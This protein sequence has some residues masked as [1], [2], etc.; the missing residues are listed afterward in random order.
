MKISII[1]GSIASSPDSAWV[2]MRQAV[3]DSPAADFL[4]LPARF[5]GDAGAPDAALRADVQQ[6]LAQLAREKRCYIVG[7]SLLSED[8]AHEL[9]WLFDR[10]GALLHTH[11]TPLDPGEE[12]DD[13]LFP[14]IETDVGRIGI[15]NGD[16]IWVLE[17][18]RILSLQGAEAVFVP[19]RLSS[20]NADAKIASLWGLA[21]LNCV[22]IAFASGPHAGGLAHAS[23][24][25]P[26][27]V[28]AASRQADRAP[29]LAEIAPGQMG[30]LRDADL[31]FANTLWFGLWSR[32]KQLYGPLLEA[33][34]PAAERAH[35]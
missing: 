3:A 12:R 22:A 28:L 18:T 17:S 34:T 6:G 26:S 29:L 23:V 25:L 31:T 20:R 9:T 21:T 30:K 35:A 19:A 14:V 4:V 8:G 27:G 33:R 16:D 11:C 7:G 15:L 24:I 1:A 5:L 13:A 10:N 32:R 2:H